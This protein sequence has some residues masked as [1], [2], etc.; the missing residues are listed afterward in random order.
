M[1]IFYQNT[2]NL[3]TRLAIWKIEEDENYFAATVPLQAAITHPHKRLQHLAGR[4]LLRYLFPAFPYQEI[5]IASTKKPY[6]PNEAFHFS[7][8]HCDDYAAAI[9]ST[10]YRV[11]I[12]IEIITP[13]VTKIMHKYLSDEE[14]NGFHLNTIQQTTNSNYLQHATLLWSIKEAMFKWWGNGNVDFKTMLHIQASTITN[15]GS[16]ACQF[17]SKIEKE[18]LTANYQFF[19]KLILAYVIS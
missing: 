7:I 6:L 11:G 13:R 5:Q 4:Y 12:D 1:P 8:S 2:I 17:V 15:E 3:H 16:L 19:N 14:R 10:Q 9:V 18:N